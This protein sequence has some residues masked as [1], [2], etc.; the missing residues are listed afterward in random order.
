VESTKTFTSVEQRIAYTYLD[1]FPSFIPDEN[2]IPL[3][4]QE[5][6]YGLV[7]SIYQ[8]AFDE[9]ELFVPALHEDDAFPNRFNKSTYGKPELQNYMR[10][11]TKEMDKLLQAMFLMGADAA[12]VKLAKRQEGILATLGITQSGPL[13]P[14]WRWMSTRP[15]ASLTA[16]SYC[17]FKSGYPY[18]SDA[19]A[20]LLGDEK[21]YRR[22]EGW[23]LDRGYRRYDGLDVLASDDKLS[24]TYANPAWSDEPPRGGFEYK[25][26][27][28]GISARY[29]A[30][31]REPAVFGLCIPNGL[32]PY[33]ERFEDMDRAVQA[34]VVERTKTCD[35]CGYCVQTDKTGK[36]PL[37]KISITYEGKTYPLCP[38]FPGCSYCWTSVDDALVD[39]L[40]GMLSFMDS[41]R[42]EKKMK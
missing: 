8:L 9:P 35:G 19:Y 20:R 31:I 7:K 36:R 25:I 28:T 6:F 5:E 30:F 42:P 16:F 14:G 21:A 3:P 40:I 1:K 39:N 23:M 33:L 38:Y 24:I 18:I 34:F 15:G 17:L 29:D 41:V 27:H 26:R 22:L 13:P 11:F 12:G 4:E 2:G 10:K 37:A 32:K